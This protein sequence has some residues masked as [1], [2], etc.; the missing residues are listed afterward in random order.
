MKK[1]KGRRKYEEVEDKEKGE[2]EGKEVK[3]EEGK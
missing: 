2:K 3:E 1:K